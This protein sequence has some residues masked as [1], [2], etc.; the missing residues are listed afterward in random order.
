MPTTS[1]AI[2][3]CS[4]AD[5]E[6]IAS[7]G[8]R[9]FVEAYGPTHPEPELSA[10]LARSFNSA[11]IAR[12]LERDDVRVLVVEDESR[13]LIGYAF[14]RASSDVPTSVSATRPLEVQ[15]FY[16]DARWHGQGVAQALMAECVREAVRR[17]SD[18]LWLSVWQ[19]AP[20]PQAFYKRMGFQVVGTSEFYFGET[21]EDDFVVVRAIE[22]TDGRA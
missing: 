13:A 9:L 18:A 3:T 21:V 20:R 6:S 12:D 19:K 11:K 5:A 22:A 15:R 10:Y 4:A 8:S 2:R 16:V 7:L 14:L 17:R 1:Y